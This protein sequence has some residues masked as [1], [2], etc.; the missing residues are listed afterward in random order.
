MSKPLRNL[1]ILFVLVFSFKASTYS[2]Q[3]DHWEMIIASDDL[4][5]YFPGKSEPSA[6][7]ATLEFIPSTWQSGIGGIGYDDGDDNTIIEMVPSVFIRKNFDIIA[8][9]NISWGMLHIDYDDAFVAYLN[10]HEIARANIGAYGSRP[11]FSAYAT[12][13]REAQMYTGGL[14][15]RFMIHNDTIAKYLK[16]GNNVFAIQVHNYNASSSDLSSITFFSLGIKNNTRLYR[17]VPAWFAD[18]LLEK[19][20]LPL[21]IIETSGKTIVNE[22]KITAWLKVVNNGEGIQNG[23]FDDGTDYNGLIG[24]EIRGQS[25]QMFPKKSYSLETRNDLGEGVNVSLL[26]MPAEEDWILYAPYSDKTMLRNA[27]TYQLGR[28]MGNWQP[29]FKFCEV[30]VNAEYQGVYLLIEKIKRDK[31]RVNINKLEIIDISGDELTGGYILKVDKIQDLSSIEYFYTYPYYRYNNARNYAFTYVYPDYDILGSEQKA[32]IKS[33]MLSFENTLNSTNFKDPVY[34]YKSYIDMNSFI[35]F[36]IMNE[37]SNNVDGYRY[38]TFFHKQRDSDG[39]KLVA[40]PLWDFNLGYGNVNYSPLNLATNRWLYPNYGPNEGYAMHWWARLMEDPNYKQA[41][42][43]RWTALRSSSFKTDS[44]MSM[45]DNMIQELGPSIDRNFKKW[46]II[47]QYVWPNYNYANYNYSQ[48]INYLKSWVTS[49]LVWMDANITSL[50]GV[51][52][53]SPAAASKIRIYPNPVKNN[54]TINL[55]VIETSLLSVELKDLLGKT[56]FYTDYLPTN[57][58]NQT[59][60]I[61]LPDFNNGV[62]LLIISQQSEII[63][64]QKLIISR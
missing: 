35:D 54:L 32:Y 6:N 29:R 16:T 59:I 10:G 27:I 63:G 57:I 43:E 19:S 62:Y 34:G 25:S 24:I 21:I 41:F 12:N 47:G 18:P 51:N 13:Y 28:T 31:N 55:S 39:G 58:G 3:T 26:G 1:I 61:N 42:Y 48:E 36:Q 22:P 9:E 30:Y 64:S 8:K 44:I 4:F 17:P 20:N 49:R 45:I 50:T 5:Q 23:Y 33:F 14:P 60:N 7:W 11:A 2:Q 40:G 37:L 52:D 38:S 56:I 15:E 53:I 46:P